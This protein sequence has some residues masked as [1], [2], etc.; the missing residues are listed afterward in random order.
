MPITVD[1]DSGSTTANA[2]APVATVD[3]YHAMRGNSYWANIS[4]ADVKAAAVIR[5]TFYIEKRFKTQFKG[6]KQS[7]SQSLSWPRLNAFDNSGWPFSDIPPDLINAMAEYALRAVLYNTLAPDVTRATPSQDMTA[8][9]PNAAAANDLIIGPVRQK[10]EKIGPIE[11]STTYDSYT[12]FAQLGR[13]GQNSRAPQSSLVNDLFI[14][15]YPEADMF[16]ADLIVD[17]TS[18]TMA[19]G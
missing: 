2:Y 5:A 18:I 14:P 17:S 12:Q 19:R 8:T 15:Q 11:E 9:D 6:Y 3:A 16:L 13:A 7:A 1:A 10:V 4:D